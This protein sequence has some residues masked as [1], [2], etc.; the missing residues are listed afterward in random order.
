MYKNQNTPLS[1]NQV[2]YGLDFFN[3]SSIQFNWNFN[4]NWRALKPLSRL[5][6]SLS[7]EI[8][9]RLGARG[10]LPALSTLEG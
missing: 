5:K 10:T 2:G 6:P 7:I 9:K 3:K 8:V 1:Q 4:E